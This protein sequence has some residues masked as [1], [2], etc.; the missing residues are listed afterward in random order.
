MSLIR[1][2]STHGKI[3][4]KRSRKK[5]SY[6]VCYYNRMTSCAC[7]YIFFYILWSPSFLSSRAQKYVSASRVPNTRHYCCS[8]FLLLCIVIHLLP[9][10]L[11]GGVDARVSYVC[12]IFFC[13]KAIR[14][15]N[16]VHL[17]REQSIQVVDTARSELF[18]CV[19]YRKYVLRF[20]VL[21]L[22]RITKTMDVSA[23]VMLS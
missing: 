6:K 5:E 21:L 8:S 10:I 13:T 15:S 16:P 1:R 20:L 23:Y 17:L 2:M 14:A 22:S 19:R 4:V 9:H 18:T 3:G 11:N 12:T 7:C